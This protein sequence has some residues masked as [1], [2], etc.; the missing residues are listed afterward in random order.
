MPAA[1]ALF[2]ELPSPFWLPPEAVIEGEDI[3]G[4]LPPETDVT[5]EG[6]AA[7]EEDATTDEKISLEEKVG[8]SES[9]VLPKIRAGEGPG[10]VEGVVFDSDGNG[11]PGVIIT[12]PEMSGFQVRTDQSGAFRLNTG[13]ISR[14]ALEAAPI[15]GEEGSEANPEPWQSPDKK[16]VEDVFKSLDLEFAKLSKRDQDE[17]KDVFSRVFGKKYQSA[18]LSSAL[19]HNMNL[20]LRYTR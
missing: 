12:F 5:S 14:P 8:E 3:P 17:K 18:D 13:L 16:M 10:T 19:R 20:L 7:L 2:Q 15:E 4:S 11:V 9:G 6:D 1:V